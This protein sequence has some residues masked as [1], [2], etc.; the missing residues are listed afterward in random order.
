MQSETLE[1]SVRPAKFARL[2][3]DSC[4][5]HNALDRSIS[6]SEPLTLFTGRSWKSLLHAAALRKDRTTVFL[7]RRE[8]CWRLCA[9]WSLSSQVLPVVHSQAGT[10]QVGSATRW[11]LGN[12]KRTMSRTMT[13]VSNCRY[14]YRARTSNAVSKEVSENTHLCSDFRRCADL[15]QI[16]SRRLVVLRVAK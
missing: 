15:E 5:C 8:R 9:S 10:G 6:D 3:W 4:L 7:P 13:R 16:P 1:A 12:Y 14:R 11:G 2:D